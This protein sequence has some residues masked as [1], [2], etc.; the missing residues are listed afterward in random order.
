MFN[1]D[2]EQTEVAKKRRLVPIDYSEDSNGAAANNAPMPK[3]TTAE[4]KRKCIKNLIDRIPTAKTE[5]F[6]YELDWSMVDTV[7]IFAVPFMFDLGCLK[8]RLLGQGQ[9]I[10]CQ[11]QS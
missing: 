3:P 10:N 6:A 1:Q 11:L 5:L 9:F 2:D 7:S 4:E 8:L